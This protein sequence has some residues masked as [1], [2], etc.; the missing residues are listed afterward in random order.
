MLEFG[1]S[2]RGI[3]L[4]PANGVFLHY[5]LLRLLFSHLLAAFSLAPTNRRIANLSYR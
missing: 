3:H 5:F 1:A 4:H 2:R